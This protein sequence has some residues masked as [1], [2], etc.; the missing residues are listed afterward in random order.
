[1]NA[2][3][4]SRRKFLVATA[5]GVAG[6]VAAVAAKT[7]RAPHEVPWSEGQAT[8]SVARSQA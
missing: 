1:M 5:T 4:F 2:P 6:A 7:K 3:L 8:V